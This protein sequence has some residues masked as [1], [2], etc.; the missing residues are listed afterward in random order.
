VATIVGGA[1]GLIVGLMFGMGIGE[2]KGYWRGP[3]GRPA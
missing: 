3:G 2:E 1:L